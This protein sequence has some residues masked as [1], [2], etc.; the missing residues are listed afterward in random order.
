MVLTNSP[1]SDA[2]SVAEDRIIDAVYEKYKN[3][4]KWGIVEVVHQ[5]PEWEDPGD[6]SREISYES[7]LRTEGFG[8]EEIDNTLENIRVQD[9][10]KLVVET[11]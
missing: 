7:V 3:H 1:G 5:L 10:I 11:L 2:L 8:D 9:D 4:S 6:S